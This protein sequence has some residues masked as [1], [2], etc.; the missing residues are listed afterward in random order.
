MQ[1]KNLKIKFYSFIFN[2]IPSKLRA[3][4]GYIVKKRKTQKKIV[5]LLLIKISITNLSLLVKRRF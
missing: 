1:I 2:Y 4:I 5:M 3:K